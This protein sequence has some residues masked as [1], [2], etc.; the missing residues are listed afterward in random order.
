MIVRRKHGLRGAA[1]DWV[2]CIDGSFAS[3]VSGCP[4]PVSAANEASGLAWLTSV[5]DPSNYLPTAAQLQAQMASVG[6]PSTDTTGK[7][8]YW[9]QQNAVLLLA[10]GGALLV[11]GMASGGRRR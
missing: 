2:A 5:V 11:F 9:I 4:A 1:G 8:S 7:I 10:L 3:N 6:L